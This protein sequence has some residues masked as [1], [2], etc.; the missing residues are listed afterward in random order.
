M[1]KIENTLVPTNLSQAS[2]AG[3][4]YALDLAR[5]LRAKVTVFLVLG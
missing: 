2:I 1:K 3:V 4:S 5:M